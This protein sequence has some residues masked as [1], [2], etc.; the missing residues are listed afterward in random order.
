VGAAA[1]AAESDV[2][3]VQHA[4]NSRNTA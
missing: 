4:A 3:G 2:A 1:A